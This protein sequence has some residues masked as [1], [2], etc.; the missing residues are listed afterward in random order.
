MPFDLDLVLTAACFG[1]GIIV[2]L[3]GMGGGALMTP[4][5]VLFF[6]I[7]P[8][9]A[10][11]SDLVAAAVMKPFGTAV[12]LRHGSV[13]KS[14][15]LWLCVGSIPAAFSGV[16]VLRA[17]GDGAEVSHRISLGLGVALL[18]AAAGLLVRGYQRLAERA[19][20]LDGH[21]PLGPVE[22]PEVEV[23]KLRTVLIGAIGGLVVGMTSVGSGSLIIIA[24]MLL[25][26]TLRAANLVGT[27]L[28]Q[29]VPLVGSAALAHVFFGDFQLALTASLLVGSIPGVL[30][31]AQLSAK[32]PSALIR[33]ALGFVLLASGLKLLGLPSD[34][35]AWVLVATLLVAPAAWMVLR[36][37]HG[38][39]ALPWQDTR[40]ALPATIQ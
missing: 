24:L 8:L 29:A 38:L 16:F 20:A 23:R 14:L 4:V 2:G 40:V 31:G 10:I 39:P 18:L 19:R 22:H 15:V 5:L 33:R 1:I 21:A 11:S 6:G 30:I 32:A 26:P 34:T 12:H 37:A 3:T 17:L 35:T 7:P 28:A 25:Y 13:N 36:R 9:A 27:D